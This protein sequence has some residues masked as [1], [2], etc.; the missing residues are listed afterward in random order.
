VVAIIFV[1]VA[2]PVPARA[3]SGTSIGARAGMSLDP[4]Q[5][6]AGV[7]AVFGELFPPVRLTPSVDV[8]IGSDQTIIALNPDLRLPLLSPPRT[9]TAFYL[10][11]GPTIAYV[12]P[13]VGDD[14]LEVGLSINGGLR[15]RMG[16]RNFYNVEVRYGIDDIP[17]W[18]ILFGVF[19]GGG[20][21]IE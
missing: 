19:F 1:T 8:G 5:F 4:D 14:D 7:Q 15:F 17:D 9:E 13:D 20:K 10:S 18:K 11:T 6:T 2:G 21:A 3:D 16:E 12:H